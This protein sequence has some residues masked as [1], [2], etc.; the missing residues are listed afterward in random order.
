MTAPYESMHRLRLAWA[1]VS[2][3][4]AKHRTK[5]HVVAGLSSLA[6]ARPNDSQDLLCAVLILLG[7][8]LRTW[9]LGCISKNE[10]L[11]TWGPYRYT[12]NPLY[13]AN[14]LLGA[15]LCVLVNH[16]VATLVWAAVF[17]L[18]Y[19]ATV[20]AEE[21]RLSATFGREYAEYC[22]V[23]PRFVGR[24][25]PGSMRAGGGFRLSHALRQGLL[26]QG[27][28]FMALLAVVEAKEDRAW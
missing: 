26:R 2:A 14:G 7:V 25:R 6:L 5:L 16:W 1:T 21:K 12:R 8:A 19:V 28:A 22:A 27:L 20:R 4:A 3:L 24:R 23:T 13:L 10:T 17:T 15:G 18:S 11:C 9:A